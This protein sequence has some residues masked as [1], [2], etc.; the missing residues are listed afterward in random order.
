MPWESALIVALWI[1]MRRAPQS[2]STPKLGYSTYN[3]TLYAGT[4]EV[5]ISKP[6]LKPK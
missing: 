6:K 2:T 4:A 1:D 3:Q 5:S